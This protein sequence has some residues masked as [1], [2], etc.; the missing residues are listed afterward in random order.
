MSERVIINEKT[1]ES[2]EIPDTIVA[3]D[4]GELYEAPHPD[5]R[6]ADAGVTVNAHRRPLVDRYIA[7]SPS[8]R[9]QLVRDADAKHEAFTVAEAARLEKLRRKREGLPDEP[10]PV[11]EST[12][13]DL[14]PAA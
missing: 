9:E 7:A 2:I 4:P 14:P 12:S 13:E 8:V 6:L 1:G 5:K 3:A 10:A 11:P